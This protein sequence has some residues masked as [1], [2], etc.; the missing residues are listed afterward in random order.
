VK[1][2]EKVYHYTKIKKGETN[3]LESIIRSDAIHLRSTFFRKYA[4]E[5]YQWIKNYSRDIIKEICLENNWPYDE[6]SLTLKPYFISFCL[7][8]NSSYMWKKY[9]DESK[10]IKLI[11]SKDLLMSCVHFTSGGNSYAVETTLPCIYIENKSNLKKQLLDNINLDELQS[12][13]SYFDRLLFLVSAIKQKRPYAEE[14]EFRHIHLHDVEFEGI[15]N[16]GNFYFR[17]K[18]GPTDNEDMWIDL[19]FPKEMLLGIE[20]GPSTTQEDLLYVRNYVNAI[21]Y[22][23]RIVTRRKL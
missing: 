19:L 14:Q 10:G 20:L 13:E 22:N 8:E 4:K 9:A 12:W 15:Y 7:D 17:D 21:G 16:N 23:P 18:E 11:F 5:D 1:E 3:I 6:D 2:I